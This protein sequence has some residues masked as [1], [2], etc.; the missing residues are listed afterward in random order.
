[1]Y[2]AAISLI[3]MRLMPPLPKNHVRLYNALQDIETS[4]PYAKID[5][6]ELSLVIRRFVTMSAMLITHPDTATKFGA[7]STTCIQ[8]ATDLRTAMKVSRDTRT[9]PDVVLPMNKY[10]TAMKIYAEA[11]SLDPAITKMIEQEFQRWEKDGI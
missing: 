7:L 5:A 6:D 3:R 8:L 4:V 9:Y 2:T 11:S 1:M 10:S